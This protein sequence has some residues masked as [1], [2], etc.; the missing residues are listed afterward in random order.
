MGLGAVDFALGGGKLYLGHGGII[1][2]P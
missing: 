1:G 2:D